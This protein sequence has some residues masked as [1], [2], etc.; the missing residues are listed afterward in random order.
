LDCGSTPENYVQPIAEKKP[1]RILIVDCCEY[2]AQP[3]DFRVFGRSE[4]DQLSYGLMSTHTL[5]LTLTIEMLSQE[6]DARIELLGIQ[7]QQ[8]ELG[9]D[10]SEPVRHVLPAVAEFVRH[11]AREFQP[12]A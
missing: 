8:T 1:D 5:P 9:E 3:G 11:W 6:T 4:I 10:L 12:G 2:G 7:P